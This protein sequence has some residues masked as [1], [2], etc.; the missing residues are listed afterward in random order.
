[1]NML[2]VLKQAINMEYFFLIYVQYQ[3]YYKF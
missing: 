3:A 1:M 2:A